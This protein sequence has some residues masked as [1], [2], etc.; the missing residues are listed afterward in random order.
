MRSAY[1]WP[2]LRTE[3][4]QIG[5]LS[6]SQIETSL[7]LTSSPFK[8]S[9][10]WHA[11]STLRFARILL[12]SADNPLPPPDWRH[13]LPQ[14]YRSCCAILPTSFPGGGSRADLAELAG[15]ILYQFIH[16]HPFSDGNGRTVRAL[17]VWLALYRGSTDPLAL[18]WL[19]I[20]DKRSIGDAWRAVPTDRCIG[21]ASLTYGRLPRR[22][23]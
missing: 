15:A 1:Q 2:Q 19:S 14:P 23:A 4:L 7:R 3:V 17:L 9:P 13:H 22:H 20:A 8:R 6:G 10:H 5:I 21:P 12:G 18:V 16:I 11:T